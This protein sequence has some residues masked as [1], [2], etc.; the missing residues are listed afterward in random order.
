MLDQEIAARFLLERIGLGR[1]SKSVVSGKSGTDGLGSP[2]YDTALELAGELDGLALALEQAAAYILR[3]RLSLADYLSA[4]R[5]H[6]SV[7]HEWHDQ[8]QM[9][10][11]R[12]LAV[13]WQTTIDQFQPGELA[14]LRLLS[15]F[16]PNPLP[17]FV[18][19]GEKAQAI[20]QESVAW[21]SPGPSIR[22]MTPTNPM[23]RKARLRRAKLQAEP[24]AIRWPRWPIT[25]WS[26]GTRATNR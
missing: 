18:L 3:K 22:R 23:I 21:L 12:S 13:T 1:T 15:W 4:W 5:G 14:L 16:A 10:Y 9:Q 25:A 7:V 26:A 20:W 24:S 11:P 2:S 6:E 8:R 17:M 19:E